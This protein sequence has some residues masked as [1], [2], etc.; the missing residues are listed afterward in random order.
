MESLA[1]LSIASNINQIIDFSRQIVSEARSSQLRHDARDYRA[2]R[3]SLH[4]TLAVL[5]ATR[6][7]SVDDWAGAFETELSSLAQRC[8]TILTDLERL[9]MKTEEPVGKSVREKFSRASNEK[10]LKHLSEQTEQAASKLHI[11]LINIAV[12]QQTQQAQ[13]LQKLLAQKDAE[14]IRLEELASAISDRVDIVRRERDAGVAR[15]QDFLVAL[16]EQLNIND[17]IQA[18][19]NVKDYEK[20]TVLPLMWDEAKIPYMSSEDRLK[21]LAELADIQ[22]EL[23]ALGDV[24]RNRFR[25]D[26]K[27]IWK[28]PDDNSSAEKLLN[29]KLRRLDDKHGQEGSLLIILYGGHGVDTRSVK[30]RG[31]DDCWWAANTS[32]HSATVHWSEIQARLELSEADCL[33]VVDCCYSGS[34]I[35]RGGARTITEILAAS[36]RESP[37]YSGARAYS[38]L[39]EHILA[40]TGLPCS[41]QDIHDE[42]LAA[43]RLNPAVQNPNVLLATPDRGWAGNSLRRSIRL[44]PLPDPDSVPEA[45][46]TKDNSHK[47][48]MFIEIELDNSQDTSTATEQWQRW[49]TNRLPP[50]TL[51]SLRF[52]TA[53]DIYSKITQERRAKNNTSRVQNGQVKNTL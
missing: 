39:L 21:N 2:T 1:A 23:T 20:V 12:Y 15:D 7:E 30:G 24:F 29:R 40:T 8:E 26:V 27:K 19:L 17:K 48:R 10:K 36:T 53:A 6:S 44:N 11:I 14:T 3:E 28:I 22:A 42:M 25:Y 4:Y 52:H 51:R 47:A 31:D 34:T 37:S 16:V 33:V 43:S 13:S 32:E 45:T 35:T 41:A 46:T 9:V 18:A 38:K 5:R 50:A 49:F